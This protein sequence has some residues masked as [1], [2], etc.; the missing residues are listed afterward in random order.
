MSKLIYKH[1]KLLWIVATGILLLAVIYINWQLSLNYSQKELMET[2]GVV[3]NRVDRF[4]ETLFQEIYTL[5]LSE[6]ESLPCQ[7][8]LS[9]HLQTITLNNP[10]IAGLI[11]SNSAHKPLCSTLPMDKAFTSHKKTTRSLT[12]PYTLTIFEQPVYLIQQRLGNYYVGIVILS[13]VL[14]N[15]LKSSNQIT[16]AISLYNAT[17][18]KEILK[19]ERRGSYEWVANNTPT[20][21]Y[22]LQSQGMFATNKLHSIDGM[23]V[24]DFENHQHVLSKIWY[25][26]G[27]VGLIFLLGSWVLYFLAREKFKEHHS[28]QTA[29]KLALK[30]NEFYPVYQPVFD[31][32]KGTYFGAE[33]LLRWQDHL[34]EV[35]LPDL[36]IEEAEITGLI[37]PITLRIMEIAFKEFQAIANLRPEFHLA[38]NIS[39]FHFRDK[40][41]FQ[42]FEALI[43]KYDI[44]PSQIMLEITE[45]ALLDK[46]DTIFITKMQALRQAGFGLAVDDYGTGHASISYLQHFPFN[47]LKIDQL[48]IKAIGTKAITESLN[49]AIIQMAKDLQLLIIA[50]GVETQEQIDYLSVNGVH[51][52]QGWYFSKALSMEQLKEFLQ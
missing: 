25:S 21:Q 31:R 35:I 46:N 10:L 14:E 11:I 38:F 32:E 45:R 5:P 37:V 47:Y 34:E 12:G 19:I 16:Q 41:F 52:L 4:I 3:A 42:Q 18:N 51:F 13:S 44:K 23:L 26:M 30:N 48:F 49:G 50:E 28:L 29:M 33:V 17:E 9:D 8:D 24:I 6:K 22:S 1:L 7:K 39:A 15:Y 43:K 2:D 27:L 40:D 36:F 20:P